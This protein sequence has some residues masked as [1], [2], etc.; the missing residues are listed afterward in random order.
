[1]GCT[2]SLV[3]DGSNG[4]AQQATTSQKESKASPVPKSTNSESQALTTEDIYQA[5]D[6]RSKPIIDEKIA[7]EQV[8]DDAE[9]LQ[10]LNNMMY[11]QFDKSFSDIQVSY[12]KNDYFTLWKAAHSL[13]GAT[14]NLGI[15]RFAHICK[16]VQQY[17][18]DMDALIKAGTSLTKE[19][20][21]KC[22]VFIQLMA[23]EWEEYRKYYEEF[24]QRLARFQAANG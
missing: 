22:A 16:V 2:S 6:L 20:T 18:Q 7:L 23:I 10:E 12:E 24:S 14:C 1:M 8:N 3:H 5:E 21:H 4:T 19:Q 9:L 15:N 17:G 13:K 11:E